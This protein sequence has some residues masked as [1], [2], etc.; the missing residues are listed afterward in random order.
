MFFDLE[1]PNSFVEDIRRCLHKDGVWLIQMNYLGLMLETNTFDNIS[2]EH[3]EYYSLASL[4]YLLNKH[5]LEAFDVELNDVNGG[6]FRVYVRH[7][8]SNLAGTAG[9]EKRLAE[10]VAKEDKMQLGSIKT[11]E[12]FAQESTTLNVT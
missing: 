4:Q 9:A 3:L 6:S 1:D 11:Y 7:K 10:L 5:S 12:A 2:H 8:G